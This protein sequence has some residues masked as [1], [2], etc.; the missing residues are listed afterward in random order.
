MNTERTID[1]DHPDRLYI[2]GEWVEPSTSATFEVFDSSTEQV[3]ARVAKAESADI[4]RAVAA[5]REAFDRGPWPSMPPE[6]RAAYMEKIAVQ[7]EAFNE[8]LANIW[9]IESGMVYK[10]AQARVGKLMSGMFR[11][12]TALA[13]TFPF[14]ESRVSAS[15]HQAYRVHEPV[16]VV[17][18]IIPWNGPAGLIAYKVAPALMAGCTV[19]IKSP[20]EAPCSGYIFAQ[21]CERIGLP[22]GVVNVV[23]AD[24]GPSEELVR[25]PGVDKITFT[26]STAT[27]RRIAA[28]GAER[29]ARVTLELGGKSPAIVLDDFD[30]NTAA[31]SI[32]RGFFSNLSGQVCHSLTRVIVPRVRHDAMVDALSAVASSMVVGDPFDP[33]TTLGP[34]ATGAQRDTVE[35]Y[36]AKG[37]QQGAT[38]A[39]G[40]R[41]PTHLSSGYYFEPTVFANVDNQSAIAQEEIFGP[42][43][44]V[45]PARDEAHA[46]ELAN[47]T[48]YGLNAA[49][50]TQDA[51]RVMTIARQLRAG[52]V[53]HNGS[54][55]DLSLGFG[56]FRQSGIGREGGDEGLRAFLESKSV[57]IDRPA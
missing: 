31:E 39:A 22:P 32:A 44:C 51:Q 27:G 33:A 12:Y 4:Q 37:V 21:I 3:A 55:V 10:L 38:V 7:C 16:G 1:L 45:I 53:G 41:R 23:T 52:T 17:A 20:P 9:S 43:L 48:I 8:E 40:G 24:R 6:E 56:G 42:V 14:I 34:L 35:R 29:V 54:R 26:G 46:I 13:R 19:V 57:V 36:V 47:E 5:A 25:H 11:Q 2:G 18:A 30:V 28:A 15:G 50:F 49:V